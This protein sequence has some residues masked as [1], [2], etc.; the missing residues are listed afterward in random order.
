MDKYRIV[1]ETLGDNSERYIIE[2]E[3]KNLFGYT[4][5]RLHDMATT[6]KIARGKLEWYNSL[7]LREKVIKSEVVE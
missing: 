6:I 1:K 3:S 4:A 5:W 2:K 7:Q